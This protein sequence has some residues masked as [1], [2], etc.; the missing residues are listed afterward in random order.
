[1]AETE[2][3]DPARETADA[4]EAARLVARR[5][6]I[7][8]PPLA[9]DLPPP[10][11]RWALKVFGIGL[12]TLSGIAY[13]TESAPLISLALIVFGIG[14][15]AALVLGEREDR[16]WGL[17]LDRRSRKVQEEIDTLADRVWAVQENEERFRGLVDA[18]GDIVV[19]RDAE[20]RIVFANRV[21][22]DLL[23]RA[24]R[25]LYGRT[26]P[27]IGIEVPVPPA[28]QV[29][30]EDRVSYS[31]VSMRTEDGLRWYAW[32]EVSGRDAGGGDIVH[33]AIARDISARKRAE[34]SL[35]GARER[36]EQ[37]SNAKSRF[38]ATVSHEIRT[39]MNG[40]IGMTKLLADTRLTAEQRTY[41]SAVT[42]SANALLALIEDLLDYSKIEAGR[43]DVEHQ[44]VA[45]RDLAENVVELLAH[46]AHV[47][48]IGIGCHVAPDVPG[49]VDA[50]PG[51]LRQVLINLVG[52]ALKF[53]EDGGVLVTVTMQEGAG[54][55]RMVR[56][57]VADTGPGLDAAD[58][59]RIFEEF[60]QAD[61]T[62]TRRHGGAGLGLAIS[63]RIVEAMD[64][65]L[66]V[67][68]E[69]G[70]GAVFTCVLPATAA[71]G[72]TQGYADVLKQRTVL[73]VSRNAME[74]EA[75]AL[76]IEAQGGSV[77]RARNAVEALETL[78]GRRALDAV[79]V[80]ASLEAVEG[81]QLR[82][83]E[84]GGLRP[85]R[86]VTL[87]APSDRGRLARYRSAG[88]A[89]FL[90]RPVRGETLVRF[91]LSSEAPGGVPALQAPSGRSERDDAQSVCVLVAEDN[92]INAMLA[93][94]AL[95]KAGHEVRVVTN[96]RE[97]IEALE[98]AGRAHFD[99]VL[100]DLH[101]PV[102]D[103]VDAITHIR[104][105]EESLSL[106]PIPI[107]VLSADGQETTRHS[108][109]A[110]GADGFLVKPIDP[111]ALVRAVEERVL[112]KAAARPARKRRG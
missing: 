85:P 57:S 101:M 51:R 14:A 25:T 33:R 88:Y 37:A 46:R 10:Q 8:P 30:A 49:I 104:R 21:L 44:A 40:I 95:E 58:A 87:I 32:T 23:S 77:I 102:M 98:G 16:L 69:P 12:I 111:E 72:S 9:P 60:E 86:A 92:A 59:E 84:A 61:G 112:G 27:D 47:K 56:I 74:T 64:G 65:E 100:I 17:A 55:Q 29:G 67:V 41:V 53:T 24:P 31:D 35:V 63:R 89:A 81:D 52:N 18:L 38:L 80:D 26:L 68:S 36:A 99:I 1:M 103:G 90:A 13:L 71:R 6:P 50:D 93:R 22:G 94:A 106:A 34:T 70:R 28:D 109:L 76:T 79:V 78:D 2:I 110:H 19:H 91:L 45:L 96:G 62:R 73:I 7:E 108:T 54:E 66:T 20:G 75:M 3:L 83:L 82:Q 15:L 11:S 39:P 5:T 105:Q 48:G 97:A 4:P 107:F 42:T 43:F